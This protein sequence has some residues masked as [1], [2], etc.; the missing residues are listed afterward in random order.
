[1]TDSL[2]LV[3]L[4][5]RIGCPHL[6][7]AGSCAEYAPSS[8]DLTETAE[9]APWSAYG[10]AKASLQLLLA[11]S[12]RPAALTVSWARLFNV[13]GPGEH[14][15]RLLPSV[16]RSLVDGRPIALTSGEQERDFLDVADVAAALVSLGDSRVHGVVNVCS[17]TGVRLRDLLRD[18]AARVG[19]EDLL[20]FGAVPRGPH[21]ADRTVGDSSRLRAG[22]DWSRS[23][24]AHQMISRLIDHWSI[25][26]REPHPA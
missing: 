20:R 13:I 22:T 18:V 10:A 7:V 8:L 17:G 26:V 6:V 25:H 14:P 2:D 5:G 23:I 9:V 15:A 1:L 4:L 12:L 19:G 16:V 3:A 24:D 21:D 11:S